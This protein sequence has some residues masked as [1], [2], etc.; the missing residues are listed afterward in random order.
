MMSAQKPLILFVCASVLASTLQAAPKP[1]TRPTTPTFVDVAL[2]PTGGVSGRFV[3]SHGDPIAGARATL[4]RGEN[5]VES[6]HTQ[7]DG[8]Y[9]F[10]TAVQGVYRVSLDGQGQMVRVWDAAIR[11]PSASEWLTIV[12][13]ETVVRG[14]ER[15]SDS[16]TGQIGLGI[17]IAGAIGAGIAIAESRDAEQ[18]T[19]ALRRLLK[20]SSP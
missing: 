14:G 1:S 10:P 16:L 3:D 18:E 4:V 17:G 11:P 2:R 20:V 6:T 8:T 7:P 12:R 13:Q 5:V 19:D 15:I 9:H